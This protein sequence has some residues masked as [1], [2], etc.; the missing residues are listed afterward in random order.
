MFG[1]GDVMGEE[2]RN[3]VVGDGVHVVRSG[4]GDERG[5]VE[6]VADERAGFGATHALPF[7]DFLDASRG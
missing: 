6:D 5:H 4:F 2:A 1:P 3:D 7:H